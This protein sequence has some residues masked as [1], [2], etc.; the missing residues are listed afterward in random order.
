MRISE[1]ERAIHLLIA[2]LVNP[3]PQP[4]QRPRNTCTSKVPVSDRTG[5]RQRARSEG[6]GCTLPRQPSVVHVAEL[7]RRKVRALLP[8]P[9]PPRIVPARASG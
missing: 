2:P 6:E 5:F 7:T 4:S 1:E 9:T 8:Q 3:H